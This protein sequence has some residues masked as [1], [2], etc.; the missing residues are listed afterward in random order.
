MLQ[1][2]GPNTKALALIHGNTPRWGGD[3]NSLTRAFDLR[4][5]L[6]DFVAAAI[7]RN[8]DGEYDGLP[9]SLQHDE[10]T[11]RD[12]DTLRDI[13]D[14]LE[15]F[16]RW[17]LKLQKK[18]HFGQLHDI[19]PAMDELLGQLEE[20]KQLYESISRRHNTQHI[21]TFINAAWLV[22]NK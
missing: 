20:S 2:L 7:R 4:E 17:Q 9:S 11:I 16:H 13:M 21:R 10:L 14:I 6:E 22:L 3:Y 19:F 8:E 5:P 1:A 18:E 12:W 15:P